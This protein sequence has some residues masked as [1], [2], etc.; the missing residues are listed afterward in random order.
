MS[1]YKKYYSAEYLGKKAL[2]TTA[3]F[4]K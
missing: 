3:R 2:S 1:F 4:N